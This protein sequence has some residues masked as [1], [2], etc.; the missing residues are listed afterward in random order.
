MSLI[1][2]SSAIGGIVVIYVLEELRTNIPL[3]TI[4]SA[5]LAIILAVVVYQLARY[6]A[7]RFADG[8]PKG[9]LNAL[10]GLISLAL[11]VWIATLVGQ[12]IGYL[13]NTPAFFGFIIAFGQFKKRFR[14]QVVPAPRS[15]GVG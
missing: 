11:S 5:I 14:P 3:A 6:V 7:K 15:N 8:P 4:M 12:P 1:N 9:A 13:A 2:E 10:V